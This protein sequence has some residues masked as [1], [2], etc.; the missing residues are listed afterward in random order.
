MRP[1]TII[2]RALLLLPV[3]LLAP[4]EE[5]RADP[6]IISGGFVQ[7]SQIPDSGRGWRMGSFDVR[8]GGGSFVRGSSSDRSGQGFGCN[9]PCPV[10]STAVMSGFSS[11]PTDIPGSFNFPGFFPP[12]VPQFMISNGGLFTSSQLSFTTGGFV[13]PANPQTFD[14][15]VSVAVPF[16][17]TGHISITNLLPNFSGAV[18]VFSEQVVGSGMALITLDFTDAFLGGRQYLVRSVNFQF[19]PTQPTPEPMTLVLLG[20]G[21][22]GLAAR[23]RRTRR[24]GKQVAL[25][26][27]GV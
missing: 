12:G 1:L 9:V 21:L 6:I 11:L 23:R 4:S 24:G 18:Q 7:M 8:W 19:Q 14:G 15:L 10:G 26:Q 22:A 27:E 13:I 5:V 2:S 3:L 25:R 20:S 17:M 16:T